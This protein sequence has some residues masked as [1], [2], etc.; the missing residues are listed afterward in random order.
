LE[1]YTGRDHLTLDYFDNFNNNT[2]NKLKKI[3]IEKNIDN[4]FLPPKVVDALA[5][6]IEIYYCKH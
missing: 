6:N 1:K 4:I 3:E 5:I 2:L